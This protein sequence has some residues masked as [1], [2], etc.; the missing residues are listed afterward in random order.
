MNIEAVNKWAVNIWA[1]NIRAPGDHDPTGRTSRENLTLPEIA[2]NSHF[3]LASFVPNAVRCVSAGSYGEC[4]LVFWWS[5][6]VYE[7]YV[8]GV[9]FKFGVVFF[10]VIRI[11][12]IKLG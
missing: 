11:V 2:P 12:Y 6:V 10:L 1:V 9:V 5:N 7:H 4:S 8:S 3:G